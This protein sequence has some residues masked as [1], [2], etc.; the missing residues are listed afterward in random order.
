MPLPEAACRDLVP[1]PAL[2]QF[3]DPAQDLVEF[4]LG[5]VEGVVLGVH[6]SVGL[7]DVERHGVAELH[8]PETVRRSSRARG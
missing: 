5:D 3:L 8:H 6:R 4:V 7:D 1:H 2:V